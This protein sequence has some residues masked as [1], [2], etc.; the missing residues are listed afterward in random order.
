MNKLFTLIVAT[1]F[2]AVPAIAGT[3]D[4][5]ETTDAPSAEQR[6][7]PAPQDAQRPGSSAAQRDDKSKGLGRNPEDC[8][9]GCIGSP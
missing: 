8:N 4:T 7:T 2:L 3:S 5:K 9:K 1:A 6:T